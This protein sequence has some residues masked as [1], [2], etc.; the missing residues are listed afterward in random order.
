MSE[1][2]ILFNPGQSSLNIGDEIIE[3]A[4]TQVLNEVFKDLYKY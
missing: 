1:K 2:I 4:C 3:D